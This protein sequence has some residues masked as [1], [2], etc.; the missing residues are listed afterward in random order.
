MKILIAPDKF[1][2]SLSAIEVGEAIAT[3]IRRH[4]PTA[5]CIIHPLADGGDGSI[6]ALSSYF[7]FE[8]I[9]IQVSD[10]LGR[11]INAY[12]YIVDDTAFIELA[13]A[14][15]IVLLQKKERDPRKTSSLGSG[16]MI[17]DALSKEIQK[18]FLF[19]GGSVVNEVGIGITHALGFR[20][21]D[22]FGAELYPC[23]ENLIHIQ[24]I[25]TS[26]IQ[27]PLKNIQLTCLC[28]VQ[29]LLCGINGATHLY[30]EQKGANKA[31]IEYLEKGVNH[32]AN[33]INEQ[34]GVDILAIVGGG[35]SGGTAAGLLGMIGAEAKSGIE[36]IIELT[37]FEEQLRSADW[38]ISGEG[39]LD[40]QTMQGKVSSGVASL[41]QQYQKPL[42]L[43]V[44]Q[45]QITPNVQQQLGIHSINTVLNQA[46]NLEDA[47][48]NTTKIL[49][50]LAFEFAKKHL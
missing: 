17:A 2:E 34:L 47:M 20:F 31:D 12:Y 19:L 10:P 15:G 21:L 48:Q 11:I 33:I 26:K 5:E 36:T 28:D 16:Q 23:G 9:E 4:N 40:T 42:S 25:D 1:K 41:S 29:S 44:G 45:N 38:V 46:R 22:K 24:K 27:F 13:S 30:A 37:Q 6:S 3:G 39:K 8:R 50:Q 49:E 35:A 14:S 43:F 32:F 7:D 18:I